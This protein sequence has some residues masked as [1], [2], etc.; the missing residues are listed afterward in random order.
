LCLLLPRDFL[1]RPRDGGEEGRL[2]T[3][4]PV[5]GRCDRDAASGSQHRQGRQGV[6]EVYQKR[7]RDREGAFLPDLLPWPRPRPARAAVDLAA[8]LVHRAV[9]VEGWN[10]V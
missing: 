7:L 6:S 10:G 4:P 3:R 5:D 9:R 1:W 8:E 2:Q